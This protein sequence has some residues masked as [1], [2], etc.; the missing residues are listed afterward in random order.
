M[1]Q[2]YMGDTTEY[3]LDFGMLR[4][5]PDSHSTHMLESSAKSELNLSHSVLF[6]GCIGMIRLVQPKPTNMC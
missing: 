3:V 5:M 1:F 6:N 2:G 4:F